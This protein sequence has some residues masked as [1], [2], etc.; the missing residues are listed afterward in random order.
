MIPQTM[1]LTATP[2]II[3]A[4]IPL[5]QHDDLQQRY[6]TITEEYMGSSTEIATIK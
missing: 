2:T 5:S 6:V 3:T 4:T 1:T